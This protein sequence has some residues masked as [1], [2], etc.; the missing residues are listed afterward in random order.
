MMLR[1]DLE[2]NN[3]IRRFI[4]WCKDKGQFFYDHV[5][6]GVYKPRGP[7]G[8]DDANDAFLE[9]IEIGL[10][11]KGLDAFIIYYNRQQCILFAKDKEHALQKIKDARESFKANEIVEA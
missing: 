9:G 5:S 6:D 1:K 11:S 7:Y 3:A 4:K 8:R 10:K 2:V